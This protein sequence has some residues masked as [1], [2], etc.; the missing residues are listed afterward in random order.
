M[1]KYLGQEDA[2]IQE[3][4]WKTLETAMIETAR[5]SLVGRRLLH[6]EGPYGFGLKS[7]PLEDIEME[8]DLY[9]AASIPVPS[10][11]VEFAFHKRDL[12]A[13]ERD[14]LP[15]NLGPLIQATLRVAE[16]ED[17]IVF[18][19][20]AGVIGL[21]KYEGIV[22]QNISSWAELGIAAGDVINAVSALDAAGFHGPYAVALAP[23][24]YNLL[25]R[26][27][28]EGTFSELE[29]IQTIATEGVFKAP[30]LETGGIVLSSGRHASIVLG[31]DMQIAFNGATKDDLEFAIVESL[32]VLIRQPTA[33]CA[34]TE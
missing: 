34:L 15:I 22:R 19:G 9:A 1:N 29:Q 13:Y 2:P 25:Y 4:T 12:A 24:L 23:S 10:I 31:Q 32:T 28:P 16:L 8:S 6:L 21:L 27:H 7:V 3:E 14:Q 33:I 17:R 20:A 30:A 5:H 26:R 18:N 11:Q